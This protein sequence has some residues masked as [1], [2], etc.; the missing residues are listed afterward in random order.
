MNCIRIALAGAVLSAPL[1]TPA[2]AAHQGWKTAAD[3]GLGGLVT[4]AVGKSAID[5][6]WAGEGQAGL[7]LGS[8]LATTAL[9]KNTVPEVR[10]DR[11]DDKSFPSGHTSLSF[12]AAGYLQRRYGWQ[13]GLPATVTASLVG[14]SRVE[15]RNHYWHDVAAGAVLGEAAAYLITTP[16]DDR[17]QFLPWASSRGAGFSYS[18]RF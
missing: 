17:V 2:L 16:H 13:W 9:L 14:I 12:A 3:V 10:P 4:L 11:S 15:S 1:A 5:E 18:R 7:T 6:D 8:T